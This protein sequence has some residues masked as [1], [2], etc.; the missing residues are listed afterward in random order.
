MALAAQNLERDP[1]Y[2]LDMDSL[3]A[4]PLSIIPFETPALGRARLI[5]NSFLE[6][7]VEIYKDAETLKA[8]GQTPHLG[9]LRTIYPQLFS[10]IPQIIKLDRVGGFTR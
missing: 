6:S 10:G 2:E 7:A 9:K 5:K 8:H 4:L 1:E 3:H